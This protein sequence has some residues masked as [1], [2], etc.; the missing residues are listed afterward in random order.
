[1]P[2]A[3]R[4]DAAAALGGA[5]WPRGPAAAVC[6]GRSESQGTSELPAPCRLAAAA[7]ARLLPVASHRRPTPLQPTDLVDFALAFFTDLNKE[8]KKQALTAARPLRVIISGAPASGKGTQASCAA[9]LRESPPRQGSS[10]LRLMP[11]RFLCSA[12]ASWR[13]GAWCTS[14]WATCCGQRWPPPASWARRWVW[15]LKQVA[16]CASWLQQGGSQAGSGTACATTPRT[17]HTVRKPAAPSRA[18]S[19]ARSAGQR[20]CG[21]ERTRCLMHCTH[22]QQHFNVSSIL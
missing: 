3:G 14:A 16:G 21:I 7:P 19:H 15:R 9:Q 1:M 5:S 18:P 2:I 22:H 20:L 6:H 12:R 11:P 17:Q 13:S 4:N 10:L 8:K